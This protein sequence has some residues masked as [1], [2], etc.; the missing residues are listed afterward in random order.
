MAIRKTGKILY[1]I[2]LFLLTAVFITSAVAFSSVQAE[3]AA[4]DFSYRSYGLR[5]DKVSF[6]NRPVNSE[7]AAGNDSTAKVLHFLDIIN[8]NLITADYLAAISVGGGTASSDLLNIK[9]G[10]KY[11]HVYV[12]DRGRFY[13]QSVAKVTEATSSLNINLLSLTQN[14]LNSAERKYSPDGKIFYLERVKGGHSNAKLLYSYTYGWADFRKGEHKVLN[15]AEYK[16]E[17]F[18]YRDYR[19]LN[20]F[21]LTPDTI[22]RDSIRISYKDGLYTFTF[23]VN[24][25]DGVSRDKATKYARAHLREVSKSED[26]EY[27]L[28]KVTIEMWDNG[29]IR[30]YTKEESWKASLKLPLGIRPSGCSYSLTSVYYSWNPAD[31]TFKTNNS[32]ISW[33]K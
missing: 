1:G 4:K 3:G 16:A 26:L 12:R 31:C 15:L 24:L 14:L 28:Y 18:I 19:E 5:Y 13:L 2:F 25:E 21:V 11:G 17:E 23:R 27:I 8:Y 33:A 10:L 9:G 30:K 7:I 32:D 6:K 20:N 22:R 29:M